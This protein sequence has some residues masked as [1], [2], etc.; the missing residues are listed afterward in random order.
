MIALARNIEEELRTLD[1]LADPGS[2]QSR[3]VESL[4]V[5]LSQLQRESDER[6]VAVIREL[7]VPF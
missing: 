6:I 3:A 5:L 4:K 1:N 7:R 2:M